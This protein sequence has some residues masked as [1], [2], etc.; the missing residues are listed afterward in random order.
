MGTDQL[1]AG[2]GFIEIRNTAPPSRAVVRSTPDHDP[3][4]D[5]DH[6]IDLGGDEDRHRR[7]LP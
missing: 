5:L 6:G 1:C 3:D 7:C 4:H 2:Q